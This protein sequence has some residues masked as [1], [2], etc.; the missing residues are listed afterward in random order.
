MTEPSRAVEVAIEAPPSIDPAELNLPPHLTYYLTDR[1]FKTMPPVISPAGYDGEI[2][3]FESSS[4]IPGLWFRAED[5][6]N[7]AVMIL[8][9]LEQVEQLSDQLRWL[10]ENHW[11]T[12][13]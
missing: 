11:T 7:G 3:V 2:N 6:T 9:R 12:K 8:L 1:G 4:A 13:R 5:D 10:I